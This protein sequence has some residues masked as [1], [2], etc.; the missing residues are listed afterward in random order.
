MNI[1]YSIIT[2]IY[3]LFTTDRL[4]DE[5]LQ[6]TRTSGHRGVFVWRRF[7]KRIYD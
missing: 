3:I 1:I 7:K 4:R 6:D 2:I 5:G